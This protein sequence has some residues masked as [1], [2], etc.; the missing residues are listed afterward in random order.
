MCCISFIS[1]RVVD[2]VL[3]L[4]FTIKP[5][6]ICLSQITLCLYWLT[7]L[8]SRLFSALCW[9]VAWVYIH[10]TLFHSHCCCYSLLWL[11]I[12]VSFWC[13]GGGRWR[14]CTVSELWEVFAVSNKFSQ[15]I[16][17]DDRGDILF[18]DIPKSE[19]N[20]LL[21]QTLRHG[22]Y[23]SLWIE[24]D[25]RWWVTTGRVLLCWV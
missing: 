22:V 10:N 24:M 14:L 4:G 8:F 23:S 19:R 5:D 7:L 11:F 12:I 20:S 18:E 3:S 21:A 2:S 25:L 9:F 13:V 16:S 6:I 15:G 1:A 17:P